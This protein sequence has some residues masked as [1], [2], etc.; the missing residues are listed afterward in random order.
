M[1]YNDKLLQK[2]ERQEWN[3]VVRYNWHLSTNIISYKLF[4]NPL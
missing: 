2:Y 3:T 4:V 1:Y